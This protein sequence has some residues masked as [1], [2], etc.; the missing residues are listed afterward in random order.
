MNCNGPLWVC[1]FH[2]SCLE[3]MMLQ[4]H[5]SLGWWRPAEF[6]NWT[7]S[8]VGRGYNWS[9]GC[10]SLSNS[11][12]PGWPGEGARGGW[13]AL[14]RLCVMGTA[15]GTIPSTGGGSPPEAKLTTPGGYLGEGEDA[16]KMSHQHPQITP[17]I[18]F[19]PVAKYA[20]SACIYMLFCT[21]SGCITCMPHWPQGDWQQ[22][23]YW[24]S[25]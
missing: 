3:P 14:D 1:L 9:L 8:S 24:P 25:D 17:S 19:W 2:G 11:A 15:L 13:A 4:F 6:Y 18:L 12:F 22:G 21:N 20:Y 16:Q 10:C 23:S 7:E 5:S